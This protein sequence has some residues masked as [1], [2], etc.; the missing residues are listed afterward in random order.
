MARGKT[1]ARARPSRLVRIAAWILAGYGALLALIALDEGIALLLIGGAL[2]GVAALLWWGRRVGYY[3]GTVG[4]ALFAAF[5]LIGTMVEF[6][7]TALVICLL[8][9]APLVL[10]L[11]PAARLAE[12]A[13]PA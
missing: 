7:T 5:I 12:A 6:D 8:A 1:I 4:A 2:L 3:L 9:F 10:L 13:A 11:R